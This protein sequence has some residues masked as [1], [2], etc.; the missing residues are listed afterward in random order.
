MGR[1]RFL[2]GSAA[3]VGAAAGTADDFTAPAS[4]HA[5][6]RDA[7]GA[8][9]VLH[10]PHIM[11][12]S[13]DLQR[14]GAQGARAVAITEDPVRLW[15]SADGAALRDVSTRLLGMTGWDNL[16]IFRGM[17]AETRRHLRYERLD[18]TTGTFIWL[19]A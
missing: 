11:L 13:H 19:I 10:E 8:A 17:A 5:L 9:L 6:L 1:R 14:L 2:A 7:T 12:T 18:S 4:P 3:W 16:L 15:R